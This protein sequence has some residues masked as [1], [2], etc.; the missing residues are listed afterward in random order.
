MPRTSLLLLLSAFGCASSTNIGSS[1]QST[2]TNIA[3]V[4]TGTFAKLSMVAE[5]EP[6]VLPLAASPEGAWAQVAPAYTE[7]GI[8][9]TIVAADAKLAGNQ[10]FNVRRSIGRIPMR[11][12]LRCGDDGTGPNADTYQIS[13]N[14]ATQ[15]QKVDDGTSKVATVMDATA[16]SPTM[17]GNLIHCSTTG[18]LEARVNEVVATLL[19]LRK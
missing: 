19:N 7:I 12:Y 1:A 8:P 18:E 10:G 14:I 5:S 6:V 3:G 15:I 13:M 16:T 4:T 9:L 17:G 11:N 2:T